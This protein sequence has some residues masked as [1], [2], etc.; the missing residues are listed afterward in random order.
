MA[1]GPPII[2]QP[3]EVGPGCGGNSTQRRAI[4]RAGSEGA[5]APTFASDP[6]AGPRYRKSDPKSRISI[7][8]RGRLPPLA[9]T[10]A[11]FSRI[12]RCARI[13]D[14]MYN[15]VSH[16]C[17]LEIERRPYYLP[18]GRFLNRFRSLVVSQ[19]CSSLKAM[20]SK[21]L[22]KPLF[23]ARQSCCKLLPSKYTHP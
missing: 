15:Q 21:W 23:Q 22:W 14:A 7:L 16:F 19:D 13:N 1:A 12:D 20:G 10:S 11:R 3:S 4:H 17:L 5:C 18:L 9:S 6:H 2:R 8:G